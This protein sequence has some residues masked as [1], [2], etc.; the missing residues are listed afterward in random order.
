MTNYFRQLAMHLIQLSPLILVT[1]GYLAGEWWKWRR[2]VRAGVRGFE[3]M[4][5]R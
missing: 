2:R 4:A 3:V 5:R 1:L